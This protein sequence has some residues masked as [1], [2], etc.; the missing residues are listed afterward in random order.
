MSR[1][2]GAATRNTGLNALSSSKNPAETQNLNR[3]EDREPLYVA[4]PEYLEECSFTVIVFL[5]EKFPK[6]KARI[7]KYLEASP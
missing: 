7:R 1:G 2:S 5:L 3:E 6:L 4:R